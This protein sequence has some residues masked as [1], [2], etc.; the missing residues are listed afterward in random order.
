MWNFG[1][2]KFGTVKNDFQKKF[3]TAFFHTQKITH[4]RDGKY[5][6]MQYKYWPISIIMKISKHNS[7]NPRIYINI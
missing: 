6:K 3:G 1:T 7:E 5:Q 2:A 4:R